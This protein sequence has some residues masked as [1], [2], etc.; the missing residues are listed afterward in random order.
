MKRYW[1]VLIVVLIFGY[2]VAQSPLAQCDPVLDQER[3]IAARVEARSLIKNF[4]LQTK[5]PEIRI[6]AGPTLSSYD[7]GAGNVV[8]EYW[9]K[10]P[11]PEQATFS[12]WATYTGNEPSGRQL[13]QDMFYRFFFV[14][15]LGHWMQAE[16]LDQ[17]H[18]ASATL[19]PVR[20]VRFVAAARRELLAEVIYYKEERA[21]LG[22]RFTAAVEEAMA[23]AAELSILVNPNGSK[24]CSTALDSGRTPT[25]DPRR[26]LVGL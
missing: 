22:A 5:A 23:R 24:L 18:D 19:I 17:R 12:Q 9:E 15:E 14:H 16:V 13:F 21:G 10:L 25:T 1:P 8:Q 7:N 11:S 26:L 20:R 3:A 4:E 2:G 6:D